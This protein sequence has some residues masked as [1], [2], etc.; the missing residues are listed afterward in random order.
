MNDD[1]VIKRLTTYK[2]LDHTNEVCCWQWYQNRED[3]LETIEK[4]FE[5]NQIIEN[6][7]NDRTDSL[8]RKYLKQSCW[9]VSSL[10]LY[11]HT[12]GFMFQVL[13]GQSK[14]MVKECSNIMTI[15]DWMVY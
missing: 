1:G 9:I 15:R 8:R 14:E 10:S 11:T 13:R 12:T 4:D 5:T 2:S 6:Y 7:A 3:L